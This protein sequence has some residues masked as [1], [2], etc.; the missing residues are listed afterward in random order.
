MAIVLRST[1]PATLDAIAPA[2]RAAFRAIRLEPFIVA[3]HEVATIADLF[4]AKVLELRE[5]QVLLYGENPFASAKVAPAHLRLR[6]QMELTNLAMRLRRRYVGTSDDAAGLFSA[7]SDIAT[8]LSVELGVL[9][10]VAGEAAVA[11][12][13]PAAVFAA[14]SKRF[15]LEAEPLAQLAALKAGEPM[16][17]EPPVLFAKILGVVSAAAALARTVEVRDEST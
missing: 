12:D 5:H 3:E 6:A 1:S 13:A 17:N 8:P 7:L 15:G 10:R 16:E 9:L 11:D 14:A 2:L 4:P